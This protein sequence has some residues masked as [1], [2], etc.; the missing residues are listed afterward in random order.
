MFPNPKSY[1]QKS[2]SFLFY[3]ILSGRFSRIFLQLNYHPGAQKGLCPIRVRAQGTHRTVLKELSV[4]VRVERDGPRPFSGLRGVRSHF[5][6][7]VV[8][9]VA[10]DVGVGDVGAKLRRLPLKIGVCVL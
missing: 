10:H 3:S 7:D 2:V 9:K 5:L 6:E 8:G 4:E 1:A